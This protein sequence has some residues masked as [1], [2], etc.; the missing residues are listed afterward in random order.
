[1]ASPIE[2]PSGNL[3]ASEAPPHPTSVADIPAA[4][5]ELLEAEQRHSDQSPLDLVDEASMESFPCSD[6]PSYTHAHA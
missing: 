5:A 2:H 4:A 6:P 3:P 1:M